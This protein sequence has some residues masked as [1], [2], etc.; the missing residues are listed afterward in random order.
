[1]RFP[2][3]WLLKFHLHAIWGSSSFSIHLLVISVWHCRQWFCLACFFSFFPS[4]FFSLSL[5]CLACLSLDVFFHLDP[6]LRLRCHKLNY[7]Q[8][9]DLFDTTVKLMVF[10]KMMLLMKLLIHVEDSGTILL[11][12]LL[13]LGL[14]HHCFIWWY[15][16][17]ELYKG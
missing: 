16:F 10:T 2:C 17:A 11:W 14:I 5:H 15:F 12:L 1:M 9:T 13:Y 7:G 4:S 3:L 8:R 6:K